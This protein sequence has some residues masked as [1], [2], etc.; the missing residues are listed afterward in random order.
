MSLG[1]GLQ[2]LLEVVKGRKDDVVSS[3]HQAHSCQQL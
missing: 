3:P 2:Y 1:G